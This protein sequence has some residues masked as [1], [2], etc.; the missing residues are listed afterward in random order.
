ML[1]GMLL[2]A[3]AGAGLAAEATHVVE[4][5]ME[6]VLPLLKALSVLIIIWGVVCAAIRLSPVSI[7]PR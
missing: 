1:L 7:F 6:F 4:L 2:V 3:E 5:A